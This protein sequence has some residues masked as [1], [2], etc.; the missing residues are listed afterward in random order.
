MNIK[1]ILFSTPMVQT[2]LK[3]IKTQTRRTKGLEKFNIAPDLFIN[4]N[5][6]LDTCRFWD[7]SIEQDPNPLKTEFIIE[8]SD[9]YQNRVQCPYGKEGDI[10]WVRESFCLTQPY[11]PETYYFGYKDGWHSD[12]PASSKYDFSE[13]DVWKPSIHMPKEACR[14][15]LKITN[16]RV[17]RL[18]DISEQDAKKEGV[19]NIS[20]GGFGRSGEEWMDYSPKPNANRKMVTRFNNDAFHR[21]AKKSFKS[22]WYSING[23]QSWNDNPWVWVIEFE[24]CVAPLNFLIN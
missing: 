5:R 24:R 16:V 14:I 22:L 17:E 4:N 18:Q 6:R 19:I 1:P 20:L 2:I 9:G 13:P 3:G 23:E 11:D 7:E 8:S 21:T 10:I 12:K 15:F